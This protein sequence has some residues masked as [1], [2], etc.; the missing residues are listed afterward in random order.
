[1]IYRVE[2]VYE[3]QTQKGDRK[4]DSYIL[5]IEETQEALVCVL[6]GA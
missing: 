5:Q 6:Q 2:G 3:L 1:M 4:L